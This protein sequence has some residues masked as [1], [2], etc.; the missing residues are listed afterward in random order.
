MAQMNKIYQTLETQ[1]SRLDQL[2]VYPKKEKLLSVTKTFTSQV[3]FTPSLRL[4]LM[5]AGCSLWLIEL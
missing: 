3:I 2:C 1:L 5:A 4:D